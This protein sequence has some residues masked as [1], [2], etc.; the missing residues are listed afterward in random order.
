MVIMPCFESEAASFESLKQSV[1]CLE[2]QIT[3]LIDMQNL[4]I[5][6]QLKLNDRLM[7]TAKDF[8]LKLYGPKKSVEPFTVQGMAVTIG[9]WDSGNLQRAHACVSPLIQKQGMT[10]IGG[11]LGPE[12]RITNQNVQN[13]GNNFRGCAPAPFCDSAG[14]YCTVRARAGGCYVG[15]DWLSWYKLDRTEKGVPVDWSVVC[16]K[17]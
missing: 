6:R 2:E 12:I 4:L 1:I 14:E 15:T 11:E 16:S 5:E 7:N 8:N 10:I 13:Y 17:N 9:Y 3:D